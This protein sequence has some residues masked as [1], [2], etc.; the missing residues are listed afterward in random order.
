MSEKLPSTP[1]TFTPLRTWKAFVPAAFANSTN[2][3][4]LRWP[5]SN[6]FHSSFH[7]CWTIAEHRTNKKAYAGSTC[8]VEASPCRLLPTAKPSLAISDPIASETLSDS[9]QHATASPVHCIHSI[10]HTAGTM[11]EALVELPI[12][13]APRRACLCFFVR[14]M[15]GPLRLTPIE[16]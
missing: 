13:P 3:A 15:F 2:A 7:N 1:R 8:Q 12:R 5:S 9:L 10:H 14:A 6:C 16:M 4:M 11:L